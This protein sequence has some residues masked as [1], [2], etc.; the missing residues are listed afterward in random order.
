MA[1]VTKLAKAEL[2]EIREHQAEMSER[3]ITNYRSVLGCLDPRKAEAADAAAALRLARRTVADAGGFEAELADI[4]AVAAHPRQQ[5]HAAGRQASPP[6]PR[7]DVCVRPR[8]SAGGDERLSQRPRR[9][10][11]R[12]RVRAPAPTKSGGKVLVTG[13]ASR[14]PSPHS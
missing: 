10:A 3:L 5:L 13:N 6:R 12:A 4:E 7:D 14:L 8:R 11:A 2:A 1:Q 9:R